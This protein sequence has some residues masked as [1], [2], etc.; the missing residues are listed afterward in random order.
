MYTI[1]II[2]L[3]PKPDSRPVLVLWKPRIAPGSESK[4]PGSVKS[5]CGSRFA[6]EPVAMTPA[7]ELGRCAVGLGELHAVLVH[8]GRRSLQ[9]LD[10]KNA[11][12]SHGVLVGVEGDPRRFPEQKRDGQLISLPLFYNSQFS[13]TT[14]YI[15][16][17]HQ[18]NG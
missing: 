13:I 7:A 6:W 4:T 15:I 11:Q 16:L 3:Y 1:I 10:V 14:Y 12:H 2:Q 5:I 8:E 18:K 17:H 9:D